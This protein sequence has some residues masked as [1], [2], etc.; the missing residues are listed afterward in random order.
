MLIL[1]LNIAF[2]FSC[3]L[4]YQS[5][6]ICK[7]Y[8]FFRYDDVPFVFN[9][10]IF[11]KSP[12]SGSLSSQNVIQF[13][14]SNPQNET[15]IIVPIQISLEGATDNPQA[16]RSLNRESARDIKNNQSLPDDSGPGQSSPPATSNIPSNSSQ[17]SLKSLMQTVISYSQKIK[18]ASRLRSDNNASST[19]QPTQEENLSQSD[20]ASLPSVHAI[21]ER[22]HPNL[23]DRSNN[24]A[25]ERTHF[26][27]SVDLIEEQDFN[28]PI[29]NVLETK[30]PIS[31]E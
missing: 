7:N 24:S 14:P 12:S 11:K 6:V 25:N 15:P 8:I 1:I 18:D 3:V 2:T 31:L 10:P 21:N 23:D 28:E 19:N 29:R 9:W 17:L 13:N 20:S 30:Q 16:Q 26:D 27:L 5:I 4:H 22:R